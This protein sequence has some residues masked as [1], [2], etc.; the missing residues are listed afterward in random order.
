QCIVLSLD[1][2]NEGDKLITYTDQGTTACAALIDLLAD[3]DY[4]IIGELMITSI[5]RDGT[6]MG[7][8]QLIIDTVGMNQNL[9]IPFIISGG[10]GNSSHL[11]SGLKCNNVNAVATSNLF[12]FVGNGLEIARQNLLD[13]RIDLAIWK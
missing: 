2:R 8:D 11:L 10:T 5:D 7:L 3:I 1:V 12:N 4:N 13:N 6:G 9:K